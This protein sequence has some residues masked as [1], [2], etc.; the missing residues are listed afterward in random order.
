LNAEGEKY[1][2]ELIND[3]P[4]DAIISI[5]SQGDFTDLCAGP[6]CPSTGRVKAFKLMS[7]AGAYWRGSEKNKMLQRIYGTAFASKE[8]LDAYLHMMEE[9]EKR[10]HRKLGKELEIFTMQDEGPGFPFFLPNGIII[11]NELINYWR[12]VHRRY[13]YVEISTPMI[14]KPG[15]VGTQRS[16]GSL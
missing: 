15:P 8:E 5:Y 2:V 9:A 1:K 10:D 6:H 13:G 12:E 14:L 4:K 7:I 11:K 3:L 16:L